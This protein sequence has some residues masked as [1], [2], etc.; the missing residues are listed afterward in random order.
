MAHPTA[1]DPSIDRTLAR[2]QHT[3]IGLVALLAATGGSAW[4]VA[5]A[6]A[7]TAAA[8]VGG[9]RA[10]LPI[11]AYERFIRPSVEPHPTEFVPEEPQRFGLLL[12]ATALAVAL[13]AWNIGLVSF[14]GRVLWLVV[15]HEFAAAFGVC[16][17]CR[18]HSI[19]PTT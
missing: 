2:F 16:L 12:V 1:P 5:L 10:S 15:L 9:A 11:W 3:G 7:V 17:A 8:A 19:L 4:L 13:V 6:F 18:V 14:A